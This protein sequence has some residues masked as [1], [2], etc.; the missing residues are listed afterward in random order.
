MI[1]ARARITVLGGAGAMGRIVIRDLVET[2]PPDVEIVLA[3]RDAR[4]G[5]VVAK[6]FGK[7]VA[8]VEADVRQ[9]RATA[10]VLRNTLVVVNAC[11]HTL[12]L[13]AMG[14]A[15][16]AGC[17]YLDLGGLFHVTR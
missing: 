3:D 13:D 4:A 12:N 7:R 15:L 6:P 2:A 16:A 5:R 17:H 9:V 14:A 10:R 8:V 11:H 1:R